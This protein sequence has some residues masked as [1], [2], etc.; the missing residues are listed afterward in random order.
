MTKIEINECVYNIHPIYNL[1]G[2]NK[3]GNIIHIIKK[4]PILSKYK[5]RKKDLV[6]MVRS[7]GQSCYKTILTSNFVWE[8]FNG[9]TH[10]NKV[11]DHINDDKEDNRLCNLHLVAKKENSRL[12]ESQQENSV[13]N[14]HPVYDLYGANENGYIINII[15]RTPIK[16]NCNH[17]GYMMCNVKKHGQN[18]QKCM[19]VHRFVWECFN[20]IIHGNKVIDHINDDKEDNRLCN[21]QLVTHQENCKKSAKKR[22]YTFAK[23][24]HENKRCIK[25][26]NQITGEVSYYKS[27]YATQQRLG[28]NAGIIKMVCEGLNKCKSGISKKDGQQYIFEYIKADEL[29]KN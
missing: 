1:Y 9:I 28:I 24:N 6:C 12:Y 29:P 27:M 21:L 8:C 15:K 22:D 26:I 19:H 18:G 10:D 20:G 16:G 2:A 14:I 17:R 11:I 4:T 7:Y 13:Y 5:S 23:Y 25:A 3:D